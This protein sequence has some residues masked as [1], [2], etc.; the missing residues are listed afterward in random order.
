M[1]INRCKIELI[2]GAFSLED[3]PV[4]PDAGVSGPQVGSL[5]K[6]RITTTDDLDHVFGL[7]TWPNARPEVRS[8]EF[9]DGLSKY[10][11]LEGAGRWSLIPVGK[12][13]WLGELNIMKYNGQERPTLCRPTT[14]ELNQ[15]AGGDAQALLLQHGALKVGTREALIGDQTRQRNSPALLVREGDVTAIAAG[16]AVTRVMAI[17]YELG[18]EDV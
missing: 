6:F 10:K 12:G 2:S 4:S 5:L 18:L 17:M 9:V 14:E 15:L 1:Q 8:V 11:R 7:V 13:Q 16:F 3:N